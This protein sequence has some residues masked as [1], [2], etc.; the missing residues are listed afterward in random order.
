MGLRTVATIA[1]AAEATEYLQ[2]AQVLRALG[3]P[4]RNA[5]LAAGAAAVRAPATGQAPELDP[6]VLT[7][8]MRADSHSCTYRSAPDA[9]IL[10]DMEL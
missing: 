6:Q 2:T 7:G 9:R 4:V 1:I 3:Q 5:A 8:N 10:F